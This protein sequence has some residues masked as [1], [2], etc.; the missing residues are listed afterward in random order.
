[1]NLINDNDSSAEGGVG[2]FGSVDAADSLMSD[3]FVA[4][5]QGMDGEGSI[6]QLTAGTATNDH[7]G[8]QRS[9]GGGGGSGSPVTKR[10]AGVVKKKGNTSASPGGSAVLQETSILSS[11][12]WVAE[13]DP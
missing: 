8:M 2:G 4:G 7:N 9:D 12:R 6:G 3:G 13:T 10:A 11:A 5:G 1:M